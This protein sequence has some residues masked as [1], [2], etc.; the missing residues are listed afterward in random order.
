M[1]V[2]GRSEADQA[3]HSDIVGI[4]PLDMLFASQGVDDGCLQGFGEL[5]QLVMRALATAAAEQRDARALLRRSASLSSVWSEGTT[6]DCAGKSPI[7]NGADA[8]AAG[9]SATSPGMTITLTQRS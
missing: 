4:V 2:K 9:L 1:T 7:G 3:G 6:I 5:Y 8:F